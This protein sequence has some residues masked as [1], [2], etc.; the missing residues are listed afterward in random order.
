M[1]VT[2]FKTFIETNRST[3]KWFFLPFSLLFHGLLLSIVI[4]A[5]LMTAELNFPESK[6]H[7]IHMIASP[8][9]PSA[10]PAAARARTSTKRSTKHRE[11]TKTIKPISAKRFVLPSE[12]PDEIREVDIASFGLDG[13]DNGGVVGGIEGGVP[14]GVLGSLV[15]GPNDYSQWEEEIITPVQKPKLIKRV[16]PIY[17]SAPLKARIQGAVIIEAVTDISGNVISV[18]IINGHPLLRNAAAEA[19]KKWIYEP[20]II[21]G[22]P[23]PVVFT[24]TVNFRIG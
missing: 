19:V 13:G 9:V 2:I 22:N 11:K 12:V 20:Y 21:N 6:I 10:P 24:V 8:P 14:G 7:T 16:K 17:P 3:K 15:S 18:K 5:P 1:N 23:K 4:I